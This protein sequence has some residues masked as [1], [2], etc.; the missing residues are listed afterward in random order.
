MKKNAARIWILCLIA[1]LLLVGCK[2]NIAKETL[3]K[4]Q[5]DSQQ[6][7]P[8][9]TVATGEDMDMELDLDVLK[10]NAEGEG[11]QQEQGENKESEEENEDLDLF[12]PESQT[13]EPVSGGDTEPDDEQEEPVQKPDQEVSNPQNPAPD[14]PDQSEPDEQ[15]ATSGEDEVVSRP[16]DP[17]GRIELPMIPG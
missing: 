17:D 9:G 4:T 11:Q 3:P 15:E 7:E 10:P 13:S 14:T 2:T 8:T 16:T 6:S 5:D 12:A 1:A